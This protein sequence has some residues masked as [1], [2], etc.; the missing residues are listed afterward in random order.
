MLK[1]ASKPVKDFQSQRLGQKSNQ[2]KLPAFPEKLKL[3]H[4]DPSDGQM[5]KGPWGGFSGK[6]INWK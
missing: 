1:V 4:L 6:P 2:G 3:D 5:E